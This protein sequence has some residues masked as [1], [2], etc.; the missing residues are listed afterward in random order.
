MGKKSTNLDP[1][2]KALVDALDGEDGKPHKSE[3][4]EEK[5]E[6]KKTCEKGTCP[7]P[8]EEKQSPVPKVKPKRRACYVG[9]WRCRECS[10]QG[11][12]KTPF[13]SESCKKKAIAREEKKL[14]SL[15]GL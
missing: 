8:K 14:E 10:K 11:D 15:R 3:E 12:F 6:A 1:L 2:V 7:I 13:C 9:Y 4:K 5:K